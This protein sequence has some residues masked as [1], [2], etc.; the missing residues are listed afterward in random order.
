MFELEMLPAGH[1]DCLLL[2]WGDADRPRRLLVDGGTA[3]SYPQL[4]QR[5]RRIPAAQR[6]ID[7]LVATHIDHDHLGGLVRLLADQ[8]LGLEIG[9]VWFN[10]WAQ[11]QQ[12]IVALP[13]APVDPR[14]EARP[15]RSVADAAYLAFRARSVDL[16]TNASFSGRTVCYERGG[17]L[18]A[19]RLD[20]GL[21]LTLLSPGVD[22][23]R[24]L[25]A[26]WEAESARKGL[27]PDDAA[28]VE[29]GLNKDRRYQRAGEFVD[30]PDASA[31][32]WD[33]LP[34]DLDESVANGSSIALLAEFEGRRCV[35]A[36]DAY[37][38]VL[39]SALRRA[40]A[41]RGEARLRLAA[42]KLPHHGSKKNVTPTLV[43]AVACD[44]F[45]VSTNG[46]MFGHPDDVAMRRVLEHG[47][48]GARLA[49]NYRNEATGRWTQQPWACAHAGRLDWPADDG[50]A[51]FDLTT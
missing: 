10:G 37:A 36:G 48:A 42:F 46:A 21:M 8:E 41:D 2:T 22:E 39:E 34:E 50:H 5:L 32:H 19:I 16:E 24:E 28:Q 17:A 29:R 25:R 40:A 15:E 44:R 18:P 45:L 7:V 3:A 33:E 9:D 27:D 20:D 51:R 12:G 13:P 38:P 47:G 6:R 1:G 31:V 11:L 14:E 35:L 49:F 23:L 30:T 4:A 26:H 43:Q